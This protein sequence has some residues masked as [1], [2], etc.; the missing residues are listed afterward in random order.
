MTIDAVMNEVNK[1]IEAA[2]A[3]M[4][5]IV[6]GGFPFT[7]DE[8]KLTAEADSA[9]IYVRSG[10]TPVCAVV[11]AGNP[12]SAIGEIKDAVW[13]VVDATRTAVERRQSIK[14]DADAL[15]DEA[16]QKEKAIEA[17][18]SAGLSTDMLGGVDTAAAEAIVDAAKKAVRNA[19]KGLF[20][21]IGNLMPLNEAKMTVKGHSNGVVILAG[22]KP[23]LVTRFPKDLNNKGV[24]RT[25]KF[26]AAD[27]AALNDSRRRYFERVRRDADRAERLRACAAELDR[28]NGLVAAA[29]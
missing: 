28:A 7:F 24:E 6:S 3:K 18:K 11:R 1:V 25:L 16:A 10:N 27:V 21:A 9:G 13:S 17:L 12:D 26:I 4:A 15:A 8:V 23:C 5:D 2:N 20:M 14:A 19:N 22:G 29:M